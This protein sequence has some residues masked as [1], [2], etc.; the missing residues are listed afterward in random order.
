[1]KVSHWLIPLALAT[2]WPIQSL[3][4]QTQE[5]STQA[6][7]LVVSIVVDQMRADYLTRFE[8]LY[9]GGIQTLMSEGE[10][11]INA[12]YSHAPTYTGPG[13]ATIYTGTDPRFHGIIANDWYDA[14]LKRSVYC[15][16]D[17]QVTPV[18]SSSD[19][20]RRSPKNIR[21]TTWT[22]ELEWATQ[23][24]A[25][26]IAF[27]I[28]DRGAICAAGH[29]GDAAYWID[30]DA[31]FVSS[32]HYMDDLP[33]WMMRFN[34]SNAPSSYMTGSWDRL[35]DVSHYDAL[36]GPDQSDFERVPKGARSATFPYDLKAMQSAY[37]GAFKSTP[38]GNTL[39]VDAALV[40]V[41]AEG[42][43]QDDI[44]DVLAISF[45]ATDYLGHAMGPR[46]Q[47]VMDMYLRLDLDL[48]HLFESL[49]LLVGKGNYLVT[50]TADHGASDN[51]M[52]AKA[53][54]FPAELW[55][56]ADLEAE[57]RVLMHQAGIDNDKVLNLSNDQIYLSSREQDL[58]VAVRNAILSHP[59][60]AEA[61]T[62]EEIRLSPDPYAQLRRNGSD[63]R[64]G[65]VFY[66]LKPGHLAYGPT[67]TTHGS[68]YHYDSHVPLIFMGKAFNP[69]AM[70]NERAYIRDMA[71]TLSKVIG[72]AS[73]S[74]CTGN[75]LWVS[76]ANK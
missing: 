23:G 9:A 4:A 74:A 8:D 57:L 34:R 76:P 25:K 63:K 24:K 35:L 55:A 17:D 49:D 48:K 19:A 10:S 66:A 73:P 29:Y 42:L 2:A 65:Q 27:S 58:A 72:I 32:S 38:A 6:P 45:S 68:G 50:F 67:G 43:G 75:P 5:A 71:P 70:H 11:F 22:D 40:A 51:P 18:G 13:H 21:S 37:N 39:L 3:Q 30:S 36:A 41:K 59:A 28:K 56:P 46:S 47:E 14:S 16:E 26:V 20:H 54:G 60:I 33:K 52:Q 44:T 62:W 12:H 61:W 64:S 15:V 69:Q 53:D 7:K 1:M 31:G